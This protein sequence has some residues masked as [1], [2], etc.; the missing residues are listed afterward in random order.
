MTRSVCN[1][2]AIRLQDKRS[3][4]F[5]K[6]STSAH[7]T[8]LV[9]R[10]IRSADALETKAGPPGSSQSSRGSAPITVGVMDR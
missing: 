1:S 2:C 5:L 4:A 7:I 3:I 9:A 8:G 6:K 10:F